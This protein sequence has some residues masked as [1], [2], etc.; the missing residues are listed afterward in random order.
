MARDTRPY[1]KC[2]L[3]EHV[4]N[5]VTLT[6]LEVV[7]LSATGLEEVGALLGVTLSLLLVEGSFSG[8]HWWRQIGSDEQKHRDESA[9]LI[10]STK[11]V[12]G[13]WKLSKAR[14]SNVARS[15]FVSC[16]SGS[17]SRCGAGDRRDLPGAKLSLPIL[18]NM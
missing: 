5:L 7:A 12:S 10:L 6:L 14:R 4:P 3:R 15:W 13:L 11:I 18:K 1:C 16:V 2:G 8:S 17:L 9:S